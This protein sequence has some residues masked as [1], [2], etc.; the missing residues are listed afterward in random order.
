MAAEKH[1][2]K[3]VLLSNVSATVAECT[4]GR[5]VD[6][7]LEVVG[8]SSALKVAMDNVRVYGVVSSCG[9]HSADIMLPG[10][11]LYKKK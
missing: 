2:A 10:Q 4:A 6:A 5:G 3:A 9:V 1:G 11:L 8:N 7:A